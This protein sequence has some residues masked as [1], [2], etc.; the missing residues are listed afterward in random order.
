MSLR[1]S[2]SIALAGLLLAASAQAQQLVPEQSRIEFVSKQMGVPV[3]GQFTRFEGDIDFKP[4][5][6]EQARI[7]LNIDTGSATLGIKETD[8]EL[9][10][11][12]WF[13]VPQ[14]PQASFVSSSV[15]ATGEGRYEVTGELSIK[16]QSQPVTVPVTLKQDGSHG[17]AEG[18]FAIKRLGF[19]IGAGDWADT[20]MVADEVQVRFTLALD[21]L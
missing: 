20:S 8:A 10:K 13:N 17:T 14:F 1:S 15:K 11:P 4:A 21:G 16:G 9:P 19:G 2:V 6:P 12:E 3:K 5:Q 18:E 7:R